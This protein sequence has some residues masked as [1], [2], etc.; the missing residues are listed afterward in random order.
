MVI[1]NKKKLYSSFTLT[2]L[3]TILLQEDISIW[4]FTVVG[5]DG[6]HA[7]HRTSVDGG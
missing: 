7:E 2:Y 4:T 5:T 3:G 1:A 6:I